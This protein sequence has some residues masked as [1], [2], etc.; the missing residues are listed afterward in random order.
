M[1]QEP[2][3]TQADL[4]GASL[5]RC[6]GTIHVAV[7]QSGSGRGLQPKRGPADQSVG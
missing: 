6:I 2:V 1:S 4:G 7:L 5:M 3:V